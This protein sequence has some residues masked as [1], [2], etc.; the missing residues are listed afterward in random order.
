MAFNALLLLPKIFASLWLTG[1][2][3]F[4]YFDVVL[5]VSFFLPSIRYGVFFILPA[6]YSSVVVLLFSSVKLAPIFCIRFSVPSYR[7]L[8]KSL[9]L[10]E[11][12]SSNVPLILY[13]SSSAP[14]ILASLS[15]FRFRSVKHAVSP[16]LCYLFLYCFEF[17]VSLSRKNATRPHVFLTTFSCN[18]LSIFSQCISYS[19]TCLGNGLP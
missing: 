14:E 11:S 8:T 6:A 16:L 2:F 7:K 19:L 12:C 4:G 10:S 15:K 17:W 5:S 18:F 13:S 9:Y 3:F 1:C